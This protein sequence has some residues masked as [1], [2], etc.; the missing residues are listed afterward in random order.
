MKKLIYLLFT[1]LLVIPFVS[2]DVIFGFYDLAFY[3]L[4][5]AI[6]IEII[7]FW[8]VSSKLFKMDISFWKIISIVLIANIVSMFVGGSLSNLDFFRD[9]LGIYS[10]ISFITILFTFILS[11]IVEFICI[12]LFFIRSGLKR[13]NFFWISLLINLITY[14]IIGL[15]F[16]S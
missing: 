8:L 3:F 7:V 5:T 16:L 15:L 9:Y 11:V 14:F 1:F 6:V 4:L 10:G 2:A 12:L 13:L